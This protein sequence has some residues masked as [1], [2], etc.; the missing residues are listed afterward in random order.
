MIKLFHKF[1]YICYQ[2]LRILATI[3][4]IAMLVLMLVEVVRR[5]IFSK[6]FIWSDEVIRY[7]LMYCT[8][9][10]GACAY[11][12]KALV[13]FD[14]VTSRL[15][16]KAQEVLR[17]ANNCICLAL[18]VFLIRYAIKKVTGAA[19]VKSISTASGLSLAVPYW[20]IPIGLIFMLIFTL[21]FFPEL[22]G[23]V[24]R[25]FREDSTSVP[26]NGG[27]EGDGIC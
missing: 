12:K 18:F 26:E 17:L 16:H 13:S 4:V 6:T 1:A 9:L 15:P 10:G 24:R 25:A 22:I 8:F 20:A 2:I 21:D 7:L 3:T 27:K 5:Y 14:L 19:V 11:Y 23:N